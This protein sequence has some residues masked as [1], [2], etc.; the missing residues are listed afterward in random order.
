MTN[1]DYRRRLEAEAHPAAPEPRGRPTIASLE[2]RMAVV[3]VTGSAGYFGDKLVAKLSRHPKVERLIG[4]DVR[5]PL[6]AAEL[7]SNVTHFRLDIRNSLFPQLVA[8]LGID[9]LIHLA[10]SVKP[11][12]DAR[13]MHE[14][15]LVGALNVL[16][17]AR[18]AEIQTLV[19]H[20]STTIYGFNRDNPLYMTEERPPRPNRE[21]Q[22]A[23]DKVEVETLARQFYKKHPECRLVILRPCSMT[24]S[25][26]QNYLSDYLSNP[27]VPVLLGYD[28]LFQFVHV[29][30]VIEATIR[31]FEEPSA[32]GIY[33]VVG[34]GAIPLRN[35]VK[36]SGGIPVPVP[37]PIARPIADTLWYLKLMNSTSGSLNQFRYSCL[38]SSDRLRK[39]LGVHPRF[40]SHEA[41]VGDIKAQRVKRYEGS[42]QVSGKVSLRDALQE[43]YRDRER[44]EEDRIMR[45]ISRRAPV[46]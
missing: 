35:V 4:I 34:D 33:N 29:D 2:D 11:L 27:V 16:R 25:R 24:G 12:H 23:V 19:L 21:L 28:P 41:L 7:P 45:V 5:D 18:K 13:E 22:Y 32:H 10:F 37:A 1:L 26:V 6:P 17:A 20:S 3:A 38:A 44:Q 14:I 8:S 39:G 40:T 43:Y 9:T 31:A 30:D 46:S 15:N 42:D 36:L